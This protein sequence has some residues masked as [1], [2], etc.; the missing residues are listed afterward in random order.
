MMQ[1]RV[2]RS[3]CIAILLACVLVAGCVN[4][5]PVSS[6]DT[7]TSATLPSVPQTSPAS[8][9][10][11]DPDILGNELNN[12]ADLLTLPV[13]GFEDGRVWVSS[14]SPEGFANYTLITRNMPP[15]T[16]EL[17]VYPVKEVRASQEHAPWEDLEVS[18]SPD[19]LVVV[20]DHSYTAQFRVNLT[21]IRYD[22]TLKLLPYYVQARSGNGEL[23]IADDWVLVYAGGAIV[24]GVSGF[25]H[26]HAHL[27]D[28][29]RELIVKAGETGAAT[30]L[31]QPGIGCLG[32]VQYNLSL[33]SGDLNM[34]PMPAEEKRP[35]PQG[36]QVTVS[37]NN[38][39][40]RSFGYYPSMLTVKTAPDLPPGDYH[41]LIEAD[42]LGTN[43]Q[44]VVHV[45]PPPVTTAGQGRPCQTNEEWHNKADQVGAW[46][47]GFLIGQETTDDEIRSI[48]N[49]YTRV[50]S[51]DIRI[52]T[53]HY[54]GYYTTMPE[55]EYLS[56]REMIGDNVSEW[57]MSFSSPMYGFIEPEVKARGDDLVAPVFI[58]YS[59]RMKE[60]DTYENLILRN[61]SLTRTKVVRFDLSPNYSPVEREVV[62][63]QLNADKKVLFVFKEYLEGV[64]C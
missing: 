27:P 18:I 35:F 64:L 21:S 38:Y 2:H 58:S 41:I 60:P 9:V 43:D 54:V 19:H 56:F 32:V 26:G 63:R 37:P 55:S 42:G 23:I 13:G 6:R 57:N 14:Y 61:I 3:V 28:S 15:G 17:R 50:V 46:R 31:F 5:T 47:D 4:S 36:L 39:T 10:T 12:T 20:P 25:Y 34:M 51:S 11:P 1:S 30:Y 45:V 8:W 53:P 48:L 29:E 59:D 7:T 49:N 33:V 52:S 22:N 40:A 44:C 16:V 62:L 24:P